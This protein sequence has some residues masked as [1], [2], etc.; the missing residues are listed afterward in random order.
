MR[1]MQITAT[2]ITAVLVT[3]PLA[4]WAQERQGRGIELGHIEFINNCAVC[5]G[6]S[7]LG[8]GP[9]ARL[10]TEGG[11]IIPNLTALKTNNRGAFPYERV[12]DVIDGRADVFAHGPR[13]M[14]VW[15]ETFKSEAPSN[16]TTDEAEL[17]VHGRVHVLV[18]YLASIQG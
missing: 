11:Q 6:E 9:L 2:A 14:P 10:L 12:F 16:L 18:Q 4:G 1:L 3:A 17:L 8:D 13:D 15:G 5:H 7:A